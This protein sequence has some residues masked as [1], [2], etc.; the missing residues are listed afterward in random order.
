MTAQI[1]VTNQEELFVT[2]VGKRITAFPSTGTIVS[3]ERPTAISTLTE[4]LHSTASFSVNPSRVRVVT[5]NVHPMSVDDMHFAAIADAHIRLGKVAAMSVTYKGTTYVSGS[6]M[7]QT[8]PTRNFDA[9]GTTPLGWIFHGIF[10]VAKV[11]ALVNAQALTLA[12]L[13]G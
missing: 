8:E 10:E 7:V 13:E 12:D 6:T 4:G 11:V 3:I 2:V 1:I 5:I 9:D